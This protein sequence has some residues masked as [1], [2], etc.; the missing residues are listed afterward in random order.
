MS[1]ELEVVPDVVDRLVRTLHSSAVRLEREPTE[2]HDL[3]RSPAAR[4][5][6]H[7]TALARAHVAERLGVSRSGL[8]RCGTALAGFGAGVRDADDL[9]AAR[10]T[11]LARGLE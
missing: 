5:L 9:L 10:L 1:G 3:R 11:A 7:H 8:E 2:P 4:D 6:A